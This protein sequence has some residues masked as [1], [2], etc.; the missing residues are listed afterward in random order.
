MNTTLNIAVETEPAAAVN[1]PPGSG[2]A[3]W[4]LR[5]RITITASSET[6]GGAYGLTESLI[7]P[8]F[9][10][11]LHIHHGEDEAFY[12]LEGDLTFRCGDETFAAGQGSYVFLPRGVPHTWVVEGDR[13][14]RMLGL[15]SPGGGERFFADGGRPAKG[16]GLPPVAPPDLEALNRA[17]E[18]FDNSIVGPPMAPTRAASPTS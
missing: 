4:F 16:E 9:S 8:G 17:A 14:A 15:I 10:P 12:V 18:R 6:T 1:V 7:A 3:L 2:E 11:P 5:N 13:P